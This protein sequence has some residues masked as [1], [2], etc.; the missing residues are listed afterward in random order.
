MGSVCRVVD[1]GHLCYYIF[2][3]T[4]PWQGKL[5]NLALG[6]QSTTQNHNPASDQMYDF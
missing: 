4:F 1:Q 2:Q 5:V 3:S 6:G